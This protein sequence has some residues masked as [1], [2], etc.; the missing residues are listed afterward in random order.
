MPAMKDKNQISTII[1][2]QYTKFILV[3]KY[4][5]QKLALNDEAN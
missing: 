4:C 2:M 5:S 1:S 3:K